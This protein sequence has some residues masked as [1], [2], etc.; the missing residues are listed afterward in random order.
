MVVNLLPQVQNDLADPQSVSEPI[1]QNTQI[2]LAPVDAAP[3]APPAPEVAKQRSAKYDYTWGNSGVM[4][5]AQSYMRIS[6]G[7][8]PG[9]RED[10]ASILDQQKAQQKQ[11]LLTD[12]AAAAGPKGLDP[13]AVRNILD[14]FNPNNRPTDPSSVLEVNY[15]AKYIG[16][17]HEAAAYMKDTVLDK[18]VEQIPEQ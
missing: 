7:D 15:A 11:Q 5:S 1:E 3:V 16:S 17:I 13:M 2:S 4:D 18:A 6:K 9:L 10:I 8:E 14:P 12:A